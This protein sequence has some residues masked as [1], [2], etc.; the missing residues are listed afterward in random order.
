[1]TRRLYW[2]WRLS[3]AKIGKNV[4][5]AFPLCVVECVDVKAA[6]AFGKDHSLR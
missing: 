1:M 2:Q 4:K 3:Q 5:I 6:S